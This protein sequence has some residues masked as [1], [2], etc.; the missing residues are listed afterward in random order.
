MLYFSHVLGE[1]TE[2]VS[3]YHNIRRKGNIGFISATLVYFLRLLILLTL[4]EMHWLN[5]LSKI[6][7]CQLQKPS[8]PFT[9]ER[10]MWAEASHNADSLHHRKM[11]CRHISNPGNVHHHHQHHHHHHHQTTIHSPTPKISIPLHVGKVQEK[12][13]K[14]ERVKGMEK[15]YVYCS[16]YVYVYCKNKFNRTTI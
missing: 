10:K 11:D 1:S 4:L 3:E 15:V 12:R 8:G 2:L 5:M 13:K 14:R 9:L 16:F 7:C 6:G